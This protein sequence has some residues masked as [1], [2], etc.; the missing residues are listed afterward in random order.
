MRLQPGSLPPRKA[1]V[2]AGQ[3]RSAEVRR[4][5]DRPPGITRDQLWLAGT[6]SQATRSTYTG[7]G[8]GSSPTRIAAAYAA[9]RSGRSVRWVL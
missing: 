7:S 6:G 4:G 8:G 2:D 3:T 1:A 5:D 9:S